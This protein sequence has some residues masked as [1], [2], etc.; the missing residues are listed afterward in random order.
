MF[1][2]F[3]VICCNQNDSLEASSH[4]SFLPLGFTFTTLYTCP[5]DY[6]GGDDESMDSG[7]NGDFVLAIIGAGGLPSL[8]ARQS[9]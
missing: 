3:P 4:T 6:S 9:A 7:V 2:Q 8:V 5:P 1:P